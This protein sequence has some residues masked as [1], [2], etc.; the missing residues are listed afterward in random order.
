MNKHIGYLLIDLSI[1][2]GRLPH[3][4]LIAKLY[5]YGV[6]MDSCKLMLSYLRNRKR[7]IELRN[8]RSEWLDLKTCVPQGLLF[9]PFLF[10]TFIYFILD[11]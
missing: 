11:L 10:N 7:T 8:S 1:A 5:A 4:L 9:G 2:F 6:T 3:G